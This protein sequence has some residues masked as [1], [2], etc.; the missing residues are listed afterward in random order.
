MDWAR[1]DLTHS[2]EVLQVDPLDLATVRGALSGVTG[3]ELDLHY[4]GDTRMGAQLT[5]AGEHGWDG[6]SALRLVHAV[7]D[8]T[9]TLVREVL[10]T[11]FVTAAPW[12]GMGDARVTTF[13]L[14]S[15]LHALE[16][17]V[18]ITGLSVA[19]GAHA[20]DVVRRVCRTCSRPLEVSGDA[21]DYLYGGVTVYEPGRSWLSILF[22]VVNKA[23][24]RLSVDEMGTVTVSRYVEPSARVADWDADVG[25]P[26]GM[27]I[28]DV[29]GDT[30]GLTTPA[31]AIVR[32][33]KDG[34]TITAAASVP[35]GAPSSHSVRGYNVDDYRDVTDLSPFTQSA[36]QALAQRYLAN[37]LSE[38]ETIKHSL[39]YRPVREGMVERLRAGGESRRWMVSAGK[40]DL[41]AWTWELELKGGW[42]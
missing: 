27:V 15:A 25:D 2:L 8:H 23:G 36:A 3:G 16:T 34:R 13:T 11:F 7:S 41:D 20:L 18:A 30:L 35:D 37:G 21:L 4:Y 38:V 28:G 33:E 29:G 6:T 42:R 10:G 5:C 9:G 39:M 40:L 31:R 14:A 24:D 22:D 19:K 32:A 12:E 26:R 1:G 17:D